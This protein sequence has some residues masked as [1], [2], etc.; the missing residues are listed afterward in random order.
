[1]LDLVK[2]CYLLD[3]NVGFLFLMRVVGRRSVVFC[4]RVSRRVEGSYINCFNLTVSWQGQNGVTFGRYVIEDCPS[5][6]GTFGPFRPLRSR[7]NDG[8]LI[9]GRTVGALGLEVHL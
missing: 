6:L 4:G 7:E 2:D 8:R 1:M 3:L 5:W 9:K